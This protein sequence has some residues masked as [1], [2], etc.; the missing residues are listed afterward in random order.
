M[1]MTRKMTTAE[2][3]AA[4][5]M[6]KGEAKTWNAFNAAVEQLTGSTLEALLEA[7]PK[8]TPEAL[9]AF[10][11]DFAANGLPICDATILERTLASR[12]RRGR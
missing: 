2:F 5:T 8:A 1:K 11:R 7:R 10:E 9:A 3:D 12:G 6:T 4:T